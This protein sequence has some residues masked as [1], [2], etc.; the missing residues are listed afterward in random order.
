MMR[1]KDKKG[2]FIGA[3]VFILALLFLS[4]N[5]KSASFSSPDE[6]RYVQ[7]AEEMTE[8]GDWIT[9]R[10]HGRPRFQKPILFYWFAASGISL[11]KD[12]WAGARLPSVIFG[13]GA[14]L[15]T[16][17]I[18]INLYNR[19]A[20]FLSASF[21]AISWIFFTYSR[22][23][24]PDIT[25]LF[26]ITLS[27]Y[28]FLRVYF[29]KASKAISPLF[30]A[31]L[32][33]AV[34][35]KGLVGLLIPFVVIV[36]YAYLYKKEGLI[37]G[38][39]IPLGLFIFLLLV[40]PWFIS[41]SKIHGYA[42]INHIWQVETV[43]RA[44]RI[45]DIKDLLRYLTTA[46][47]ALMPASFFLPIAVIKIVRARKIEKEDSFLILWMI[48]VVLFFSLFGTKKVHYMLL[49]APPLCLLI[50]TLIS[51]LSKR[52]FI[53]KA[54]NAF[55][56][57]SL[58]VYIS[59][60][61]YIIPTICIDDGLMKLAEK[62]LTVRKEGEM[63]GVGSH[64][65][66]HNRLDAYLGIN[67]KKVNVDLYDPKE[68]FETSRTILA[69]FLK[70][71]KRVFCV[72]T[73]EDCEEYIPT[74]LRKRIYILDEAMYWKKPNQLNFDNALFK[75]ILK[76]DKDEIARLLKNEVLLISNKP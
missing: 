71:E 76:N 35:T 59:L 12:R 38:F 61:G 67:V 6:K 52:G 56:A 75:A 26:F 3:A 36:A 30:F 5:I 60:Y 32:A 68:Q 13:A 74:H 49:C 54:I 24:T 47:V 46:F 70:R 72:I 73:R 17:L 20:G 23:A 22:L 58:I 53:P 19:R 62:I 48:T 55:V 37:K 45:G 9:P 57:V 41:M 10:Y 8:S 25:T 51:G 14:V 16:Y 15:L 50:G 1:R 39:N 28:L 43:N 69:E 65:I 4:V 44:S 33:F 42:Y 18:G 66:S 34:L 40:L 7:S 64:F 63:I 27:I 31:A 29:D 2:I 21:L 11:L